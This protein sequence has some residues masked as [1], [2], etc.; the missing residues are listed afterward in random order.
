MPRD[1]GTPVRV[2]RGRQETAQGSSRNRIERPEVGDRLP[3]RCPFCGKTDTWRFKVD[4][5][6]CERWIVGC[7]PG[8]RGKHLPSLAVAF[9]L[10]SSAT[11]DDI[12]ARA[13]T[14]GPTRRA[15][16]NV[17]PPPTPATLAGWHARLLA[18][19]APLSYLDGRG[20][21][22]DVIR[23]NEIGWD[24]K[25]I[26]LPM[27]DGR[28]KLVAL[29]RRAPKPG[30][31]TLSPAGRGRP[32]PLYP[33]V[34]KRGWVLLLAGEFDALA[35]RSVGLPGVSVTLGAG[36]WRDD[37]TADLRGRQ[38]VVC[39]DNNEQ[40]QAEVC[41][42]R[43]RRAGINAQRLDLRSLGLDTPKG[44]LNDYLT[45]GG[46]PV[47]VRPRRIVRRKRSAA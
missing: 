34:P 32:W 17:E 11:P 33:A 38:V 31:K 44:D 16:E 40:G 5:D 13:A 27:R 45:G 29:K 28:G 39:F 21:T 12:A 37:W 14:L 22:L 24:G 1:I 9:G 42:R 26:V 7:R 15:K 30:A 43:L 20:V 4:H 23:A 41:V 3:V 47:K 18:A 25:S 8:C 2:K 35:A 10:D 6:G 19:E 46:D 36:H